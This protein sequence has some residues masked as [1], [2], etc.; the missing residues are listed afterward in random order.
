M[1]NYGDFQQNFDTV[2]RSPSEHDTDENRLRLPWQILAFVLIA[3]IVIGVALNHLYYY[4]AL[5][6][7]GAI[8]KY[9]MMLNE[10]DA[11]ARCLAPDEY[12]EY[13]AS[14]EGITVKK[15]KSSASSGYSYEIRNIKGYYGGAEAIVQIVESRDLTESERGLVGSFMQKL[16]INP[17]RVKQTQYLV[18]QVAFQTSEGIVGGNK[19]VYAIQIDGSWYLATW[20]KNLCFIFDS[21]LPQ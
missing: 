18:L 6:M 16:K 21:A 12:W 13:L 7:E 1:N 10:H 11:Q 9:Q 3:A 14:T 4:P 20:D 19:V 15:A 17:S 8:N 5:T 2:V